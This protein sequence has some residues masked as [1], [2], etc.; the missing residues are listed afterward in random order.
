MFGRHPRLALDVI[1]GLVNSH[2]SDKSH[3]T[4]VSDLKKSL[5]A[6]Y[7]IASSKTKLA[8][9]RQNEGYDLRCR[10]AVVECGDR[11]LVKIVAFDG[12]HKILDK[13]ENDP[14]IVLDQ[15]N[16]EVPVYVVQRGDGTGSKRTLHRNLLFP[17]GFL[18]VQTPTNATEIDKTNKQVST[19]KIKPAFVED[20]TS[21]EDHDDAQYRLLEID[22]RNKT[23]YT[24]IFHLFSFKENLSTSYHTLIHQRRPCPS[25]IIYAS[26]KKRHC[27]PPIIYIPMHLPEETLPTSYHIC[28]YQRRPCPPPTIWEFTLGDIGHLLAYMHYQINVFVANTCLLIHVVLRKEIV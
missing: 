8:Q 13:W 6:S 28:I 21:D 19:L 18:P 27:P 10:G 24:S 4:H 20:P 23:S 12:K 22:T 9:Q 25:P 2:P 16:P 5:A 1:L 3:G 14:Y 17:I 11:V 15:P 26:T 7:E